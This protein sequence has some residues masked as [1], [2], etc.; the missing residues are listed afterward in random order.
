MWWC[1]LMWNIRRCH[2]V[3]FQ[4]NGW[5]VSL[6]DHLTVFPYCFVVGV[7]SHPCTS[8]HGQKD[9][10]RVH[11]WGQWESLLWWTCSC[12][13]LEALRTSQ[14]VLQVSDI[15]KR[16]SIHLTNV[17]SWSIANLLYIQFK[18]I[19]RQNNINTNTSL[20]KT[21]ITNRARARARIRYQEFP[22]YLQL[23]YTD[24]WS[25]DKEHR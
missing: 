13:S 22:S 11:S 6:L 24:I 20:T 14:V 21:I 4:L 18:R 16:V 3:C 19:L 17:I 1:H 10:E 2:H 8:R 7:S 5:V 25:T 9:H 12:Q 15:A 23:L